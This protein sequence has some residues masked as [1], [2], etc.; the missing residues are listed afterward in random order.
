M[1]SEI[2]QCYYYQ[3]SS[4]F[5]FNFSLPPVILVGKPST[6]DKETAPVNNLKH[7]DTQVSLRWLPSKKEFPSIVDELK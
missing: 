1:S 7:A 4:L 6:P 3:P 5:T 2:N